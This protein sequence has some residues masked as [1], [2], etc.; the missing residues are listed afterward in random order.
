MPGWASPRPSCAP[1]PK[2]SWGLGRTPELLPQGGQGLASWHYGAGLPRGRARSCWTPTFPEVSRASELDP[3]AWLTL[4]LPCVLCTSL[5]E[6]GA[7]CGKLGP[8]CRNQGPLWPLTLPPSVP[9]FLHL[10]VWPIIVSWTRV[11]RG[12]IGCSWGSDWITVTKSPRWEAVTPSLGS[13]VPPLT[14]QEGAQ[15]QGGH[16][17]PRD[18]MGH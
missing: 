16:P 14:Q 12:A 10:W 15:A 13:P 18:N 9:Q 7:P 4:V 3:W 11:Y 8:E 5:G 6:W 1:A 17:C 2:W